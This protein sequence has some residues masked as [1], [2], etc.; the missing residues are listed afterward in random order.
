MS[1]YCLRRLG[2][3]KVDNL[4]HLAELDTSRC[5][6][7]TNW[8][9][10]GSWHAYFIQT[11]IITFNFS[12]R[13]VSEIV[14]NFTIDFVCAWKPWSYTPLF[15]SEGLIL[16]SIGKAWPPKSLQMV[17][18]ALGAQPR[19]RQ[20]AFVALI[21]KLVCVGFD[22]EVSLC[23]M[24]ILVCAEVPTGL[25]T[26]FWASALWP[27]WHPGNPFP[28]MVSTRWSPGLLSRP[29]GSSRQIILWVDRIPYIY[30]NVWS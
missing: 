14:C 13:F 27:P 7:H 2:L 9:Y 20:P 29:Q 6:I 3:Y 21:T 15:H 30:D 19:R 12:F 22:N 25:H 16:C 24:M 23:V 17:G 8:W 26:I 28:Y 1:A 4:D 18:P 10:N 5:I 11:E